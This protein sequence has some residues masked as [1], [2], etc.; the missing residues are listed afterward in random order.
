MVKKPNPI[1]GKV[2]C[3]TVIRFSKKEEEAIKGEYQRNFFIRAIG[4]RDKAFGR[5]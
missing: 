2:H 4:T 3:A 5:W 1:F